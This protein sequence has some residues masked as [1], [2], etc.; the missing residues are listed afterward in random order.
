LI[1]FDSSEM[2]VH[3]TRKLYQIQYYR[4]HHNMKPL[5]ICLSGTQDKAVDDFIDRLFQLD[6]S[7]SLG[8]RERIRN[9]GNLLGDPGSRGWGIEITHRFWRPGSICQDGEEVLDVVAFHGTRRHSLHLGTTQMVAFDHWAH[10]K[11]P[12]TASQWAGGFNASPF[13]QRHRAHARLQ[14]MIRCQSSRTGMKQH[15]WRV[16]PIVID[17]FKEVGIEIDESRV[18]ERIRAGRE[19]RYRLHPALH[20]VW[21]HIRE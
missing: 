18:I 8:D 12:Q 4:R 2:N 9:Q 16:P 13:V 11:V 19:T 14:R 15:F 7:V 1:L 10:Y 20:V 3:A 17:G 21:K 5:L 6:R